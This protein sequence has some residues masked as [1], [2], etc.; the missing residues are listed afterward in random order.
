MPMKRRGLTSLSEITDSLD[1]SRFGSP[2]LST[3]LSLAFRVEQGSISARKEGDTLFLRCR[4]KMASCALRGMEGEIL[5]WLRKRGHHELRR[6][7]W[8]AG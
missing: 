5:A 2:D 6:V 7:Q 8:S 1:R 4:D 3:Q